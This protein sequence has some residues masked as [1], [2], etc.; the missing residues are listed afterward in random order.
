MQCVRTFIIN[1]RLGN[2]KDN[3]VDVERHCYGI[4][5]FL[6]FSIRVVVAVDVCCVC[7]ETDVIVAHPLHIGKL[8]THAR[9]MDGTAAT[10]S[11]LLAS[12]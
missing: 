9:W 6:F 5:T 4:Y 3:I 10:F 7:F 8:D 11:R 2:T 12:H 1:K